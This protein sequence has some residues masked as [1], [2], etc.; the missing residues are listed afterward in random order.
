LP[1]AETLV[2]QPK[3]A[4]LVL[5]EVCTDPAA[6]SDY[7]AQPLDFVNSPHSFLYPMLVEAVQANL[8]WRIDA[9]TPD[10]VASVAWSWE[11][12]PAAWEEQCLE[13]AGR[14]AL[15]MLILLKRFGRL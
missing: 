13:I 15:K 11:N 6:W 14:E 12:Y 7:C 3:L 1:E 5:Q 2:L 10:G 4:D 9:L 8:D